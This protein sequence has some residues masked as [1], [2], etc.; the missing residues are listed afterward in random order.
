MSCDWEIFELRVLIYL[1][2]AKVPVTGNFIGQNQWEFFNVQVD[3]SSLGVPNFQGSGGNCNFTAVF[4]QLAKL[5]KIPFNF[6]VDVKRT[7][8]LGFDN[9]ESAYRQKLPLKA[10]KL[11]VHRRGLPDT[12]SSMVLPGILLENVTV[13]FASKTPTFNALLSGASANTVNF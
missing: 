12:V 8:G 2:G 10:A 13:D 6:G 4:S 7:G 5:K 9:L 3:A 1:R 11:F